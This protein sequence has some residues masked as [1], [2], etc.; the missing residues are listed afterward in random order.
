MTKARA[1]S[2]CGVEKPLEEYWRRLEGRQGRCKDCA[3]EYKRARQRSTRHR[4][5]QL[6]DS[7]RRRS[8]TSGR[9]FSLSVDDVYERLQKG[10]CEATGLPFD[11]LPMP[12]RR[13]RNPYAPSLDRVDPEIGYTKANTRIVVWAFNAMRNE[14][15]DEVL[16][17]VF[18]AWKE[19]SCEPC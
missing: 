2:A 8:L 12:R 6:W 15:P 7:A 1:C 14:F 9:E 19:T 4:A 18:R 11:F 3:R 5:R 16:D 13:A 10:R 17:T